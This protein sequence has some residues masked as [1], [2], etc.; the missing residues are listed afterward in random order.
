MPATTATTFPQLVLDQAGRLA[1]RPFL[2]VWAEDEGV[3]LALS[4]ADFSVRTAAAQQALDVRCGERVAFLAHPSVHFYVYLLGTM[5]RGGVPVVLNW[6]QPADV[7]VTMTHLASAGLLVAAP[8][9]ISE[10]RHVVGELKGL[11][12][13]LWMQPPSGCATPP[14]SAALPPGETLLPV[15]DGDNPFC[16]ELVLDNVPDGSLA[17]E[18]IA[19]I[20]FTSGSTA[21]P[22]GVP[23]THAG[24]LWNFALKLSSS[25]ELTDD[26]DAG[27]LSLL[28]NFHVIG[29]CNNFLF[30]L[31]AGV[32]CAVDRDA[33]LRPLNARRLLAA[34]NVL[35]PSVLDTS[36]R[37]RVIG[38]G[39]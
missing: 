19:L 32:R 10:A 15:L 30:N 12:A 38:L 5:C 37:V 4:F 22:K 29:L 39:L 27:T 7:L 17:G 31:F 8:P 28:P 18:A 9:L 35:R 2:Q 21:T 26:D 33:A 24:L 16:S 14:M 6:R 23:L 34:C 13:L 11:R 20:M 25:P 3:V 1:S 36:D